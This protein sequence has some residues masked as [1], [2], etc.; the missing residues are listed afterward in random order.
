MGSK[1]RGGLDEGR[2]VRNLS[3]HE[4][5]FMLTG[6]LCMVAEMAP[7]AV[8]LASGPLICR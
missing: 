3:G 8:Q 5:L 2:I 7:I 4:T 6:I 1:G